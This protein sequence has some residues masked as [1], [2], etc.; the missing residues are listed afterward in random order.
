M[1]PPTKCTNHWTEAVALGQGV[2]LPQ[3]PQKTGVRAVITI[4]PHHLR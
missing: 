1:G 4:P 3:S 2:V